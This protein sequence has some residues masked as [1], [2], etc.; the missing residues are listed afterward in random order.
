LDWK[1][2]NASLTPSQFTIHS[3]PARIKK[4]GDLFLPILTDSISI[5]KAL[6]KLKA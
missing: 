1:E 4:R 2:V 6:K 3:L 5:D